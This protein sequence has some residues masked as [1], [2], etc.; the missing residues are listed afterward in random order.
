MISEFPIMT[1]TLL[2]PE[3]ATAP[4]PQAPQETSEE[5]SEEPK[6]IYGNPWPPNLEEEAA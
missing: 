4:T 6:D 5:T 1:S 2:E 3:A